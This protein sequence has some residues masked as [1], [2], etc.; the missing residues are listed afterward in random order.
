MKTKIKD[1]HYSEMK[2][3]VA[4]R[5][6]KC[7]RTIVLEKMYIGHNGP[8]KWDFCTECVHSLEEAKR[9]SLVKRPPAPGIPYH[10][11]NR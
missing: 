8:Y 5:C 9:E 4:R 7:K 10:V 1:T 11:T 3:V 6:C 2:M